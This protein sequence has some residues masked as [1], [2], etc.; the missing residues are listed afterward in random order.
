MAYRS[1]TGF[2][3]T[4]SHLSVGY[5]PLAAL[6]AVV[7]GTL[8]VLAAVVVGSKKLKAYVLTKNNSQVIAAACHR[9]QDDDDGHLKKVKWGAIRHQEGETPGHCSFTSMDVKLPK[10]GGAYTR[11]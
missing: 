11:I 5:S 2:K 1:D 7:L 10:I 9:P 4:D 6:L 8:I 3:Q